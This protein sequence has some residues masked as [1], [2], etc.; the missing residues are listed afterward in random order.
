MMKLIFPIA[1]LSL[2][3]FADIGPKPTQHYAFKNLGK[4]EY[5]SIQL[6]QCQDSE[7]KE[8]APLSKVGPQHFD[9][10]DTGC[11]SMAY[12]YTVVSQL[13]GKVDGRIVKS[14]P[15]KT[16]GMN[17]DY[18]ISEVKGRIHVAPPKKPFTDEEL[19]KISSCQ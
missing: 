9:C 8:T 19:A 18:E 11:T 16:E 4:I 5:A 14:K 10:C 12:G 3:A 17:N 6:L 2:P 15:F 7:C 13:E 1:L